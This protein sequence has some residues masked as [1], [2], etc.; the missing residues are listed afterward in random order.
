M[1][2]LV[3]GA[4]STGGYFG[5]RLLQ[6]GRDVT[7]LVRPGRAQQL[8]ARGLEIVSP[9][10]DITLT[11][12]LLCAGDIRGPYDVILLTVKAYSLAQAL[13]DVAPAVGP[14]TVILPVLNGMKHMGVL[15]ARFG[16]DKLVGCVCMVA[17]SVDAQGRVIQ[18]GELQRLSY[19][20]LSGRP[21]VRIARL[22]GVMRDAGFDARLSSTIERDMWEKWVLLATL[23]G[24]N[25]LMRATV[26][27]V[28]AA[29]GGLDFIHA[30][31]DEV[32]SVVRVVGIPP[33][34]AFL[35]T[36]TRLLTE[37]GS[38]RTSSMYRDLCAGD[39][40][41]AEHI[42]GDL[43]A[44]AAAAGLTVPRLSAAF[45]QLAI[46]ERRRRAEDST[47]TADS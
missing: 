14:D 26:G 12:Q 32:V 38:N 5:G 41:E 45:M 23:G 21:S 47:N 40:V 46:Y 29:P 2:I 20:E 9:H 4:G 15:R 18:D 19:G 25:S 43:V 35:A 13:E 10:G 17:A 36:T 34:E 28:V 22:D 33:G 30:F 1:R 7:F 8:R 3:V 24:V 27:E 16:G 42:L 37:R 11:P 6:A 31:L 44:R 39:P